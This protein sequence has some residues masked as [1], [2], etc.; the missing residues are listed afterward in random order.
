[1]AL[2]TVLV[3]VVAFV[4]VLGLVPLVALKALVVEEVTSAHE[5]EALHVRSLRHVALCADATYPLPQ[6]MLATLS[7]CVAAV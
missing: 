7:I 5:S 6:V 3:A 2:S 4:L 1:M